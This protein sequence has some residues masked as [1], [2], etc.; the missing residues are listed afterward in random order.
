M[1]I[2]TKSDTTDFIQHLPKIEEAETAEYGTGEVIQAAF[3]NEN[4]LVSWAA[5]GFSTGEAF[6]PVKDYDFYD[7]ISG[8]EPYADAFIDSESPGQTA[9]IK[10]QLDRELQNKEILNASGVGGVVSQIAAGLTDPIYLPL[11]FA[12]PYQA[13]M[14]A[15]NAFATEAAAGGMLEALAEGAKHQTQKT[16]TLTESAFNVGGAALFSGVIGAGASKMKKAE[17]D[18]MAKKMDEVLADPSPRSVGAA[19]VDNITDDSL[20]IIGEGIVKK[21]R[22]SPMV[23]M[24]TSNSRTSRLIINQMA[25]NSLVI[26]GAKEGETAIP[27]GGSAE[28]RIKVWDGNL[29]AGITALDDAYMKYR[30]TKNTSLRQAARATNDLLGGRGEMLKPSDFRIEVG[31]AMRRG[32]KHKIPEVQEAAEAMR[33]ELFN[34]LKDA[35]INEGVLLPDVDVTTADSYLTRMYNQKKIVG[36]RDEWDRILG[37][38]FKRIRQKAIDE[39]ETRL[40]NGKK[41]SQ[42]IKAE[43]ATTDME[44]Q[45]AVSNVTN[46]ILGNSVGRAAYDIKVTVSGPLKERTLN[47]PD[48]LIEDFL[49]SDIDMIARQYK[50]SMSADVELT[51]LFGDM[52]MQ[53]ERQAIIREYEELGKKANTAKQRDKLDKQ[54]QSDINDMEAVRDRIRGTYMMP[55]DPNH[56]IVR[57]GRN[58]R[59]L[60]FVRMLGGMTLSAIPDMARPVAV[61]GLM[62]VA[63]GLTTLATSYSTFKA[64]KSEVKK[65]GIGLDMVLNS[66][67][68]SLADVAD[69]YQRGTVFEKGLK[70]VT[71]QFSKIALQSQWNTVMK[72]FTGVVTQDRILSES[73]KWANGTIKKPMIKR[74]AASGINE[75]MA[76]R[77]ASQFKEFGDDGSLLLSNGHLW[78]DIDAM[79]TLSAAVLKDTDRAIL[80]PSA[81]EKPLWTSSEAGKTVFQFKTFAATAHHKILISDLQYADAAALNGFLIMTALGTLTYGAKQYVSGREIDTKP[82]KLIIESLDR[83][84]AF[85]YFWDV[86]NTME[87]ISRG[88]VGVNA[89]AGA[90]PMSRY[91]SRNWAGALLGPTLG[92]VTDIGDVAGAGLSGEFNEKDLRKVRKLLPGQN[93][94]Y[95]RQLLD[96]LEEKVK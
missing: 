11:L 51:R 72:Q 60:N 57:A 39:Q 45:A 3:E 31:K 80:T 19:E 5:E 78:D 66:R 12:K 14:S 82:E 90:S 20:Q 95:M 37:D 67:A 63:K 54:M 84:G 81:G 75:E 26:K 88:T 28:T 50:M 15:R 96:N 89:M 91:V 94:F 41:V 18:S 8:Y 32:D 42:S 43:A 77:I 53:A 17:F 58:L 27:T 47:I 9:H 2:K 44:I 56:F 1:P 23:R 70:S 61:N 35:A 93:L 30:G 48:T 7:D 69:Y 65:M 34:P 83:S 46:N 85:G 76:K 36:K 92:T 33:K 87:K 74:L 16:R 52:E 55:N 4:S 40:A 64:A 22:V 73:V 49:E 25:E 38:W 68:T 79:E 6:E 62:P 71:D 21:A 86:N 10:M 13:G 59:D 29:A 24:A